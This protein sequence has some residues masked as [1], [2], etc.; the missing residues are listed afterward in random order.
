MLTFK[1]LAELFNVPSFEIDVPDAVS[2]ASVSYVADQLRNLARFLENQTG[3]VVD[4][5]RCVSALNAE[6]EPSKR[7]RSFISFV[8]V[9]IF[10]AI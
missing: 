2:E 7:I 8:V 9:K 6:S 4:E 1:T 5:N 10:R 3:R